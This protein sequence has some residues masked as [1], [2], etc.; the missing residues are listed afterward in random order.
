MRRAGLML[1]GGLAGLFASPAVAGA[2]VDNDTAATA[3]PL[4][5]GAGV[6]ASQ[7]T[8]GATSGAE[9]GTASAPSG[10]ARMGRT[11]W[12]R[13]RGNGHTLR[14]STEG[15]A[16][17]TVVAIY[18][19]ANTP[20]E[21]N[22]VACH[23]DL[24]PTVR[25]SRASVAN[26]V[27]GNTYL[28]QVG[29][30]IQPS[31]TLVADS[32]ATAGAVTVT[33]EGSPRPANDDRADALALAVG[34][35]VSVDSA[36]ATTEP[37]ERL[38]C[39]GAPYAAT[40]WFRWIAPAPGTPTFDASAVFSGTAPDTVMTVYR[41]SDGAALGCDD[42]AGAPGGA[43]RVRLGGSVAA[44][45][46]LLIQVGAAGVDGVGL[47]E[48]PI[49]VQAAL[50]PPDLDGDDDG[51]T[52]PQDCDDADPRRHAGAVDVP[53]DGVDQDC[54]GAD[55]LV[56]DRDGDGFARPDDCDDADPGIHRG[57]PEARGNAIDED[58]DGAAQPFLRITSGIRNRWLVF[59]RHTRV[60]R[61]TVRDAP[62]GAV[63]RATCRG[64]GCPKRA[65]RKRGKGGR[66][67]RFAPF[68]AGRRLRPGAAVVVRIT[69]P[70]RIGKL[71]RY[72]IRDRRTPKVTVR[73]VQPGERK[74][75]P[76]PKGT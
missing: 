42:D 62:V 22:R 2:A 71:V 9:P 55:A 21:G 28:V 16:F 48:G 17:D 51:V 56:L 11:V 13:L 74:A 38:D 1:L 40:V 52:L 75:S 31:C 73:C 29:A 60:K 30:K 57:V 25:Q 35:P 3:T 45:E 69:L 26:T 64:R 72:R 41:E 39:G 4:G 50:A 14:V 58:C 67:L 10:C 37:G 18:D 47:G 5:L 46:R 32:C 70:D 27:R 20:T 68:L 19:T 53:E 63:A 15:S 23:D 8:L 66:E 12:F 36:G 34:A 76:C 49:T 44:N 61:L 54:D 59:A 24:S 6:A 43:S 7:T 65:K 33:A